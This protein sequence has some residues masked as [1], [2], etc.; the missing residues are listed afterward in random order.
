MEIAIV[1]KAPTLD[2]TIKEDFIIYAD[3]GYAFKDK[4]N[5]K[6]TLAVVGDFDSLGAPPENE[7]IV[8][9]EVE[10]NFTD[11]ERAVRLAKE[12]GATSVAIYG[13]FGGKIEHILGNIALLKIAKKIGLSAKIEGENESVYLIDKNAEFS[14]EKGTTVSL[15]PYGDKC[16]FKRSSGLYYPLNN[17]TLTNGDTRGISNVATEEKIFLSIAK[18]AALIIIRK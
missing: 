15:V 5:N 18:G 13:A 16:K 1:L 14:V 12:K 4:F 3:A 17:L 11:G 8:G 9:L 2:V 10:K 6:T 7:N